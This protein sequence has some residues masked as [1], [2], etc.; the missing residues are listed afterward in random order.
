MRN[1]DEQAKALLD[2]IGGEP[3]ER[4]GFEDEMPDPTFDQ[5]NPSTPTGKRRRSGEKK[6]RRDVE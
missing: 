5:T 4:S 1:A 6:E 3:L 2:E